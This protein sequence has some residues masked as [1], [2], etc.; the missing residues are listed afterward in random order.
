[1]KTK[2]A[3]IID[4]A[5]ALGISKSTVSRALTGKGSVKE[6]TRQ[7]VLEAAAQLDYE[8]NTLAVGLLGRRTGT[9]GILV[10]EIVSPFY[11]SVISGIEDYLKQ[12]GFRSIICQSGE[13]Y[14]H[15]VE[16]VHLL[17]SHRV[18]GII[19]SHTHE[20]KSFEHFQLVVNRNVPLVLFNRTLPEL[21]VPKVAVD[22][23]GGAYAAVTHLLQSGRRRIAHI[24]GPD[25][26]LNS[27]LRLQGYT[28]ALDA[29]QVA[30]NNAYIVVTDFSTDQVRAATA[31][32]LQLP[33]PPDALFCIN[34]PVA[35]TAMQ[36]LKEKGLRIPEDVAVVGF[37][38]DLSSALIT[39]ALTTV[40][41]PTFE[42][43]REAARLVVQ[44]VKRKYR[45]AI[46]ASAPENIV[47]PTTLLVR[48]STR[49]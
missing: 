10:P 43:G 14:G 6:A 15:E 2:P 23:H 26:L 22:D 32:L 8:R 38:N 48:Q 36:V 5:Q 11:A 33:T 39:P 28:D 3:S 30:I 40:A 19:A 49:S 45:N 1:M 37:S 9:F 35:I 27:K 44:E 29:A 42:M 31:R 41:Q 18:D 24:G 34:D 13:S 21:P 25:T 47:L 4:I 16:N 46:A 12:K 17:L 20:T 7:A